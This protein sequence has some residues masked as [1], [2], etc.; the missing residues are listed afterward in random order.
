MFCTKCGNKNPDGVAF[1]T[2]CGEPTAWSS[3]ANK[4]TPPQ[5]TVE[6]PVIEPVIAHEPTKKN[7]KPKKKKKKTR[8]VIIILVAIVA[9]IIG[10][11]IALFSLL[12]ANLTAKS[13]VRQLE[14]ASETMDTEQ[15]LYAFVPK[16]GKYVIIDE[17]FDGDKD[18][19]YDVVEEAN[20]AIEEQLDRNGIEVKSIELSGRLRDAS[21]EVEERIKK[22][23]GELYGLPVNKVK[24]GKVK[25]TYNQYGEKRKMKEECY[26]YRTVLGWTIYYPGW[27]YMLEDISDMAD[28]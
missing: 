7:L 6:E 14:K 15:A 11:V 12:G 4:S 5:Q 17:I 28:Y 25:I 16:I 24:S 1:C 23:M 19:F 10:I 2:A 21:E 3:Q 27:E 26:F 22:E 18:D 8:K 13:A 20:D 9:V